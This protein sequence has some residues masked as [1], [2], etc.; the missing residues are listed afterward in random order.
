[1][2][3]GLDRIVS[4]AVQNDQMI[5]GAGHSEGI[6]Q[7]GFTPRNFALAR[8]NQNGSL[9]TS[10]DGDGK[11]TTLIGTSSVASEVALQADQKIVVVGHASDP[12]QR[13]AVARYNVN[14]SLDSSFSGDGKVT[15]A[16]A[17]GESSAFGLAI[18]TDGKIVVAGGISG[19]GYNLLAR[20]NSDGSLDTSFDGDGKVEH[21]ISGTVGGAE[22]VVQA[23]GKIL[24]CGSNYVTLYNSD[25]SL[26][27]SFASSGVFT[28]SSTVRSITLQPDGK[29]LLG[30]GA[31]GSPSVSRLN[32]DGSLDASFGSGGTAQIA[33]ADAFARAVRL[34]AD[35]RI[36]LGGGVGVATALDYFSLRFNSDGTLDTTWGGGAAS[37]SSSAIASTETMVVPP[38]TDRSTSISALDAMS[39]QQLLAEPNSENTWTRKSRF[40]LFAL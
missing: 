28:H 26:D 6:R 9:D 22:V 12:T 14:G 21:A 2:S 20:Y 15:T 13:F 19:G 27:T 32:V 40:K 23:D 30:G 4:V 34:Q 38:P 3:G 25:G 8:Y 7:K 17:L 39:I 33:L 16:F 24:V 35:G 36:V 1:M 18:Q 5:L 31:V 11:V 37:A 29:I 10:F